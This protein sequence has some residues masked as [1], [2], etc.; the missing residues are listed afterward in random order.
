MRNLIL[1][2]FVM[3]LSL[4][5]FSQDHLSNQDE[6][7]EKA[8]THYIQKEY[9]KTILHL[10]LCKLNNTTSKEEIALLEIETLY[11][12]ADY[13]KCIK[14]ID[15]SLSSI[16]LSL[17]S[18]NVISSIKLKIQEINQKKRIE[19]EKLKMQDKVKKESSV[20]SSFL[21]KTKASFKSIIAN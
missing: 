6:N 12:S 18:L 15:F 4:K 1:F 8:K 11:A 2:F 19:V 9:Q 16:S 17:N 21:D 13:P 14:L 5:S 3:L 10:Q 20:W 7:F